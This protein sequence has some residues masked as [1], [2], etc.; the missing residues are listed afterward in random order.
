[1][2]KNRGELPS[3]I[4]E[5][6]FGELKNGPFSSVEAESLDGINQSAD[7]LVGVDKSETS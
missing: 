6:D 5:K 2:F 4:P 1:M 7:I 3:A